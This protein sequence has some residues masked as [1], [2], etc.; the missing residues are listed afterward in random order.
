LLVAGLLLRPTAGLGMRVNDVLLYATLGEETAAQIG[1]RP[2][3]LAA[4]S[5]VQLVS[6]VAGPG[7]APAQERQWFVR[8]ASGP[9]AGAEL[10]LSERRLKDQR[11][12][13]EPKG[14]Q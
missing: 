12:S 4:G 6:E 11:G 2:C 9:C 5:I 13:P 8:V 14:K 7:V 1:L 3:R 10:T